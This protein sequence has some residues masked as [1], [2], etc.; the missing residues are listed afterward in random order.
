M[1]IYFIAVTNG[2]RADGWLIANNQIFV[3]RSGRLL[4]DTDPS[5]I[6]N[7][8]STERGEVPAGVYQIGQR[9]ALSSANRLT[10]SDGSQ[11]ISRFKK[12]EI[13]PTASNRQRTSGGEWG[14]RDARY[15]D[16]PRTLLRFHYDGDRPG[17]EGCIVYDDI[18][19]QHALDA[20]RDNKDTEVRVEYLPN[21]AQVRARV[22]EITGRD[23]S[24]GAG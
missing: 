22:R 16:A 9:M 14:V 8:R 20:A 2:Q 6:R 3:A 7:G 11:D 15:P 21:Q 5:K 4:A 1:P 17:S 24:T 23:P 18:R 10:M 13:L 19:A 12:F